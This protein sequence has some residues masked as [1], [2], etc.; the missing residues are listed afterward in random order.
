MRLS[1]GGSAKLQRQNGDSR[2]TP[3][4]SHFRLRIFVFRIFA[5]LPFRSFAFSLW[6]FDY[7]P[8]HSCTFAIKDTRDVSHFKINF[9]DILFL[10]YSHL[11]MLIPKNSGYIT[12]LFFWSFNIFIVPYN[13]RRFAIEFLIFIVFIFYWNYFPIQ[14]YHI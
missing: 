6:T 3:S 4:P 10:I 9:L 2:I 14:K 11:N 7:A 5:P 1:E 8:L 13:S 12:K